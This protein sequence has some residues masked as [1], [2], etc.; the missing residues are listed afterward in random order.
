MAPAG[1][2]PAKQGNNW[3]LQKGMKDMEQARIRELIK[4]YW[5]EVQRHRC[6][7]HAHPELSHME[8][9]TA[10]YIAGELRKLGLDPKEHVG[11]YGVTAVIEGCKEGPCVGLRADF[12]A[13]P[14]QEI[15]GLPFA[16]E[17]PGVMHACGHDTHAA[18]LLGAAM[19][20][21]ELKDSFPGKVKLI[22]QPSEEDAADCG[23][24]AMIA[25][26]CLED[27]KVD[28]MFG[29]H[30]WPT[31]PT[32]KVGVRNG[33]M[34]AASDRFFITVKGKNSHGAQPQDGIDAIVI[35]AQVVSALQSIVSRRVGPL[36]SAVVTIGTI[37]GGNRYNVIADEVKLEGTSR[38]LNP[39]VRDAMAERIE[40]IVR[41]VTQGMGGDYE[42]RYLRCY[43]PT[44]NDPGMF[45]VV[46]DAVLKTGG[47]EL[48]TIPENSG[49][50]GEDFSFY[51]EKVPCC[52]Y[53]LGCQKEG[54][55]FYPIHHGAFVPDL[56]ALP[57][58]MEVMVTAA[59]SALGA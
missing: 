43:S 31:L 4:K 13:L 41:G 35:A 11:G 50:G 5:E 48:L 15:T 30:V 40:N 49:L 24:K 14:I 51:C 2:G 58:G 37:R 16:S 53:W 54:E 57:I 47:E 46:R 45:K 29:Q 28:M 52:F 12:D 26:G 6:H 10:A 23:A 25:D 17:N 56:E 3:Y 1:S 38:N 44:V 39:A 7:M 9:E 33:A 18:M 59:L 19:V 21:M 8:K 36:D 22:F 20:L 55:P 34:M 27:P 32:G 42:F